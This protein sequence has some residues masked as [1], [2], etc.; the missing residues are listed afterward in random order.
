MVLQRF[1]VETNFASAITVIARRV[2]FAMFRA[3]G[4]RHLDVGQVCLQVREFL[5]NRHSVVFPAVADLNPPYPARGVY[6]TRQQHLT[7]IAVRKTLAERAS[8]E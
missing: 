8:F 4:V 1:T 7:E 2:A 5:V 3:S 6:P